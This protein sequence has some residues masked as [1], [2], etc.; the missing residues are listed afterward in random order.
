MRFD[1][2]RPDPADHP[3][4]MVKNQ[5]TDGD[6]TTSRF[7]GVKPLRCTRNDQCNADRSPKPAIA[8]ACG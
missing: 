6:R 2:A 1:I 5:N 3:L 7:H 4:N 8:R